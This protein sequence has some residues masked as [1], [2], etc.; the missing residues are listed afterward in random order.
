MSASS[1]AGRDTVYFFFGARECSLRLP[2][3]PPSRSS[4]LTVAAT[5]WGANTGVTR[6]GVHPF[7][8]EQHLDDAQ[9]GSVFQKMRGE[10][11]AQT[12]YRDLL[13]QSAAQCCF[14]AG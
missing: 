12:V 11:M 7:M 14:A 13:A 2:S 6:R 3:G 4:G 5:T 1:K 10:G 8:T 9:L